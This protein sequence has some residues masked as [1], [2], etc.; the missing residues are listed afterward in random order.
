[1]KRVFAAIFTVFLITGLIWAGQTEAGYGLGPFIA[2]SVDTDGSASGVYVSD[3]YAY[4]AD[5]GA[6]L[7]VI[8][9]SDPSSPQIAGSVDI[10]SWAEG[11][12]V[13]GSYAY[14]ADGG[15][16]LKVIDISDPSSPQIAGSVDTDG[17]AFGVYVFDSYAY[18]ADGGAGL[19]VI[20]ISDPTS[21]QVAGSLD[22]DWAK[23]VYVSGSY[24]Y[25]ADG[26]A[27]LKVI[28]ISDP[29]SPQV[30]ADVDTDD[31][32]YG[33]YV[34]DSY[35]YVAD[36]YKGLKVIDI[37]P[38]AE[39][40]N[41]QPPVIDSFTATPT[42]GQAPLTV[43]LTCQ[44]HDPDG[45]TIPS[46]Q[47]FLGDSEYPEYTFH[48]DFNLT[49]TY[50]TPGTYTVSCRVWDDED[51]NV[52]S[53][54]L[55]ITVIAPIPTWHDVT[56]GVDVKRSPRT[57][58]D[59]INR[60]FFVYLDLTNASGSDLNGPV[61]MVLDSST[62]PLLDDSSKPGLDPDGYTE[63][64]KPYFILVPDSENWLDGESLNQIRLDFK[65]MRKRLNFELKFEAK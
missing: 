12:Y 62:I 43:S 2:G 34:F 11:V 57:L 36:Y 52:S 9:I 16:G 27:G 60:C 45:G 25:V 15:A 49:H 40:D 23:S 46:I 8:D 20:D 50:D 19:K 63:D 5:G 37:R 28:D 65:L 1:M 58:Y 53:D 14:V 41:N 35:A 18:V 32:A 21:P 47:W 17:W 4:V 44:A 7:K 33:V 64:G 39:G 59:R 13:F 24:A 54:T 51:D 22:T 55:T 10:D 48:G 29:T 30:V 3:S 56:D 61:R 42:S 26:E 6:G 31:I 38:L